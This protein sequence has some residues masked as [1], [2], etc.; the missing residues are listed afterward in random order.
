MNIIQDRFGYRLPLSGGEKLPC[1]VSLTEG[2]SGTFRTLSNTR[3]MHF[4]G[5]ILLIP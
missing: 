3:E 4:F 5:G 1:D 2:R